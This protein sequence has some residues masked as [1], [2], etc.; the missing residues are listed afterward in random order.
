M[1]L[2]IDRYMKRVV[3][4]SEQRQAAVDYA[5]KFSSMGGNQYV[6]AE[7][8]GETKQVTTSV[9][10]ETKTVQLGPLT[11][12]VK[13]VGGKSISE[14][15]EGV[16]DQQ[17]ADSCGLVHA[18]GSFDRNERIPVLSS[19]GI[20]LEHLG[21]NQSSEGHSRDPSGTGE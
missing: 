4:T 6:V 20:E 1:F 9:F 3:M 11:D 21:G 12:E 18:T 2:V 15:R 10:S 19:N 13:R 16:R 8:I 14:L 5:L 17:Q 7:V